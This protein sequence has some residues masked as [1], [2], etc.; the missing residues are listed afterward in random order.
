MSSRS[1]R[2]LLLALALGCLNA[3]AEEET[4]GSALKARSWERAASLADRDLA[5][6]P[7]DLEARTVRGFARARLKDFSGSLA[8]FYAVVATEPDRALAWH[9]AGKTLRM[10]GDGRAGRAANERALALAPR[11][12]DFLIERGVNA[13]EAK[14]FAAASAAFE[15]VHG[16]VPTYPGI[17]AYRAE[18]FLFLRNAE[19]AEAAAT[20]GLAVEPGYGIHRINLAHAA[21]FAGDLAKARK[22]YRACAE[23]IDMDGVTP[24]KALVPLDFA[25]MRAAGIEVP[26]MV[27]IEEMLKTGGD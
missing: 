17:H 4:A 13:F 9:G 22:L 25:K 18:V 23:L 2:W 1:L 14:E 21:L 11:A 3:R 8:D 26:G 5:L 27:E 20:A 7:D 24:G 6:R 19:A 16:L 15:D 10:L 12:P